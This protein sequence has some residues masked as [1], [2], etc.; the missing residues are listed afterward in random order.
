MGTASPAGVDSAAAA[1]GVV[2]IGWRLVVWLAFARL[3][4]DTDGGAAG[5]WLQ[6]AV[7]GLDT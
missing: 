2:E 3:D 7:A 1:R 4:V 6:L 5:A